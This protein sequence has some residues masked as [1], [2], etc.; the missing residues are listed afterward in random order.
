MAYD[1]AHRICRVRLWDD[2]SNVVVTIGCSAKHYPKLKKRLYEHGQYFRW[3][4]RERTKEVVDV[5]GTNNIC[6]VL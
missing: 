2:S 6:V 4:Y 3:T 1:P 5:K